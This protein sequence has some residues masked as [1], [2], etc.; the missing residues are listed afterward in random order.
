MKL[1]VPY[2]RIIEIISQKTGKSL[3]LSKVSFKTIRIGYDLVVNLPILGERFKHFDVDATVN[4]VSGSDIY[5][6]LNEGASHLA[7]GALFF[8]NVQTIVEKYDGGFILHLSGIGNLRSVLNSIKL[9]DLAFYS[10][11]TELEF[12]VVI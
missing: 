1:S 8:V 4:K 10:D 6:S 7:N 2:T 9:I 11:E 12:D 3:S 5:L